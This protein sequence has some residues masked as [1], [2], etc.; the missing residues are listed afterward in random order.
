MAMPA[1]CGLAQT[2]TK[3]SVATKVIIS[4][5]NTSLHYIIHIFILPSVKGYI[6]QYSLLVLRPSMHTYTH[7]NMQAQIMWFLS[8]TRIS[9]SKSCSVPCSRQPANGR[10]LS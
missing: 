4:P 1:E 6:Y 7:K 9:P 2:D 3:T 8:R 5:Q 10:T